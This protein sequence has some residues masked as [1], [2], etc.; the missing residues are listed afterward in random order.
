MFLA[1]YYC[2]F[3]NQAQSRHVCSPVYSMS[4]LPVV[5]V[6]GWDWWGVLEC[7]C[8]RAQVRAFV[9]MDEEVCVC[10]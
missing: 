4:L 3:T 9:R 8:A 6:G 2:S 1:V 5:L 10:V 7:V